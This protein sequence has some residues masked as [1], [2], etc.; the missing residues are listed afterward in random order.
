M[1]RRTVRPLVLMTAILGTIPLAY[2]QQPTDSAPAPAAPTAA[3][4]PPAA[5]PAPDAPKNPSPETMKKAR[6]AGYHA[7]LRKGQTLFCKD[8]TEIGSHFSKENC[9]DETQLLVVLDREQAQRDQLTN[10]TC[11]GCSGK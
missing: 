3:T 9:I 7:K 2:A 1:T 10:H 4:P 5:A 11:T 8:E 6:M